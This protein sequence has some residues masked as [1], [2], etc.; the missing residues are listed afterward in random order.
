MNGTVPT[1]PL[2]QRRRDTAESQQRHAHLPELAWALRRPTGGTPPPPGTFA[3]AVSPWTPSTR[4]ASVAVGLQR[5]DGST[6]FSVQVHGVDD[7]LVHDALVLE[8]HGALAL[9]RELLSA[10]I[11]VAA[12]DDRTEQHRAP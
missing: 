8:V 3:P 1:T 12:L 4:T 2:E 10:A 11:K 5:E 7:A 6:E 9:G